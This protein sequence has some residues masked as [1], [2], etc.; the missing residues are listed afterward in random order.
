MLKKQNVAVN[1]TF[2]DAE[3]SLEGDELSIQLSHGGV[4]ILQTTGADRQLQQLIQ[5]HYGRRIHVKLIGEETAT[6]DERYQKM[7]E[8]AEQEAAQRAKEAAEARAA[9]MA[10]QPKPQNSQRRQQR[11]SLHAPESRRILPVLLQMDCRSI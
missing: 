2:E 11:A 4:N 7:M 3:F 8:Q 5:R 10:A 1:G 9:A 6:K